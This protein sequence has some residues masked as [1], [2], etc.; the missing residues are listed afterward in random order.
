MADDGDNSEIAEFCDF[1]GFQAL[2]VEL[3]SDVPRFLLWLLFGLFLLHP[4]LLGL[5]D[6]LLVDGIQEGIL[7][8]VQVDRDRKALLGNLRE[9]KAT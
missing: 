8:L 9:Q 7:L 1:I 6:L 4:L 2:F 5:L 3:E